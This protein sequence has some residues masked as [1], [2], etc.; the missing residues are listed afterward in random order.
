MYVETIQLTMALKL[1]QKISEKQIPIRRYQIQPHPVI[2]STMAAVDSR[3]RSSAAYFDHSFE[4]EFPRTK[5]I[6]CC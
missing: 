4:D 1:S 5:Y 2:S 3:R 6:D